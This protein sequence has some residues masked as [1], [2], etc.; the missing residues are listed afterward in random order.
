MVDPGFES[1]QRQK[2]VR[3][4]TST[5]AV[6]PTQPSIERTLGAFLPGANRPGREV[7]HSTT[8][9]AE[10]KYQWSC[11]FTPPIRLHAVYMEILPSV[12]MT[13]SR[14]SQRKRTCFNL[15]RNSCNRGEEIRVYRFV[16]T[17]MSSY[18]DLTNLWNCF[19]C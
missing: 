8:S 5:P 12:C 19:I 4:S 6:G 9:S 11:T 7:D 3:I 1:R 18:E 10:V 2:S 15:H 14:T 13:S 16:E 17:E